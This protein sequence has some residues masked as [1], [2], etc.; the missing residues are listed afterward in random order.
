MLLSGIPSKLPVPFANSGAKNTIPTASQITITPGA[1][2]LTDGFPPLTMTPLSAGGVA[3]FGQD[4]NGILNLLS[5]WVQ[6]QNAGGPIRYD[7]TFATAISGYPIGTILQST[8]TGFAWLNTVDG[9]T[10]NPDS[11]GSG[12]LSCPVTAAAQTGRLL[13]IQVFNNSGTYTP[14][15]G[16][17]HIYYKGVGGGG[18]GG[19]GFAT[20][21]GAYA[22]GSGGA[23]GTY[24]EGYTTNPGS[25]VITVGAGGVTTA[26]QSGSSGGTTTFGTV[27]TFPG[28]G[29]G[30]I[31]SAAT[32]SGLFAGQGAPGASATGASLIVSSQGQPGL[33]GIIIPNVGPLPGQGAMS[34]FGAGGVNGSVAVGGAALGHGAG[35]A[36]T[37]QGTS[38]AA[39]GGGA[40]GTGILIIYEYT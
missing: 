29:G 3:P 6:W 39:T 12:W 33:C 14:T 23:A 26:G 5:S 9:N 27:A 30:S 36:G 15:A 32:T 10:T 8:T 40:G 31:A 28:G 19:G 34:P 24:G 21:S 2:S 7:A 37:G 22:V 18:S 13:N 20:G 38:T 35:G 1:A 16:T 25:Q 17:T 4:F 11:G